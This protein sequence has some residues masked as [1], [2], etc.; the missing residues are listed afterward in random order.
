MNEE[1]IK[2]MMYGSIK[3][4]VRNRKYFYKGIMS[5]KFTEQ[6]HEVICKILDMYAPVIVEAI[7]ADDL[8]RSKELVMK[9]LKNDAA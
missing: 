8:A 9:T 7:E 5:A 3:E 4:L 2:N 1:D 6:G